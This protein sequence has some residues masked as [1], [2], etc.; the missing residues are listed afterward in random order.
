MLARSDEHHEPQV[1]KKQ[2]TEEQAEIDEK[3][4]LEA[5]TGNGDEV[6]ECEEIIKDQVAKAN[7][8]KLN[9]SSD[10]YMMEICLHSLRY[11]FG[12]KSF[13]TDPPYWANKN[14]KF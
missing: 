14:L 10:D 13:E 11:T 12:D 3:K 1:A 5:K 2:K 7:D 8:P 6:K 4:E 9:L